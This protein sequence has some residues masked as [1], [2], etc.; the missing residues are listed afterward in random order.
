MQRGTP[1]PT[2]EPAPLTTT[3]KAPCHGFPHSQLPVKVNAQMRQQG[4]VQRP[5]ACT[6]GVVSKNGGNGAKASGNGAHAPHNKLYFGDNLEVLRKMAAESVDLIYLDPPFNSNADYGVIYGT[7]RGASQAQSHAFKDMW[8]W[9]PDAQRALNETAER[10]LE[11]GALLD[12]FNKIFEGSHMMA[13]LAMMAV[14]LIE[15]HR[16][17]KQSGSLYLHCDPT[18]S[19]YLKML[20]DAIFSPTN[21]CNEIIWKRSHSHN[22][23][24]R[25]GPIHDVLLFYAKS[26]SYTWNKIMVPL[27]DTYLAS[28]YKYEENGRR[29]KRQDL[30][31]A[32]VRHGETGLPWKGINPTAKRRH[33]MRPPSELE[34]LEKNGLIYW[35][36]KEGAWPYLKLFL[37]E[38]QG[39]PMQDLW[40]DINPINPVAQE[41]LGYHTQKPLALLERIILSSSNESDVVLDPFCGCGTAIEAAQRLNRKWVGIDVTYLAI[42]VIEGRLRKAFGEKIRDTYSLLGKPEDP[43]DARILAARDWLEFQKWAV[44]QLGGL[45]KDKPGADGG[46]D[47]IVRYHRVGI[48]QPN[49][50]VVQVKGGQ[51]VGV[52]A[53]HKLKSVVQRE[54]AEVGILVCLDDPTKAME[55]EVLSEGEVGPPSLRVPK[56]Q[57]VTVNQLFTRHPIELPGTLDPPEIVRFMP[58]TPALKK[59]RKAIEGQAEMIF[60]MENPQAPYKADKRGKR[61]IRPVDIEV[62]RPD[63]VKSK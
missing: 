29:Y 11:A 35:P 31:G 8:T 23:A 57:I 54:K 18:A 13:Y 26:D 41:R 6:G 56:L 12:A 27:A 24:K 48:E 7:K 62:I 4:A 33:W 58:S 21:F 32:G 22:S 46:I 25:Y 63:K 51:H 14:R 17:L 30:T 47:G 28:H 10:H 52:D 43:D 9:G 55:K 60:A 53:I 5:T 2:P 40:L 39:Q 49:R 19:H 36:A 44:F 50:A 16:V 20:L 34:K 37:D 42:H 1:K 61:Q 38:R 45:P 59:R 3:G 15:L